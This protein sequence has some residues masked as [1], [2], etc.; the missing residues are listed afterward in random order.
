MNNL[1]TAFRRAL[2]NYAKFNGRSSRPTFW[3]WVL[4]VLLVLLVTRIIDGAL[5]APMLGFGVFEPNAG[6]PLSVLVSLGLLL[7]NL[8]IGARRLHDIGRTGWWLLIGLIPIIG[9]LVLLYF[10]IQPSESGSNQFGE[11]DVFP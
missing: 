6:Q 1:T 7:P 10:Y 5:I 9:T 11:P 4:A 8:A 2:S 3:W